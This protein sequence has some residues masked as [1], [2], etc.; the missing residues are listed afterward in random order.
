MFAEEGFERATMKR[1][2]DTCGVTK[3]TVYAHFRDKERLYKA[4][5]EDHLAS[6]PPP[7][8]ESRRSVGLSDS[9]NSIAEGLGTLATH[10]S[11]RKF[12]QTLMRSELS[13][14]VYLEHWNS[15]LRPY[16]DGAM[17]AF[18]NASPTSDS[19]GDGEKFLRLILAEHGLLQRPSPDS[20]SDK[21]VALF[22]R[23][24]ASAESK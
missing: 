9:L 8:F 18:A 2:A 1:I 3:V 5:M 24:Y 22:L 17:Q 19:A 21:T 14:A 15:I 7:K 4:V 16:S 20:G 6:M 10:S 13:S 23:A 12:C 11:C